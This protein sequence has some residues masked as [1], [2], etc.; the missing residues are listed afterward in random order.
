MSVLIQ[1]ARNAEAVV[2]P[3]GRSGLHIRTIQTWAGHVLA[4]DVGH[5]NRVRGR[6]DVIRSYFRDPFDSFDDR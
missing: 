4:E 2:F 3:R 1:N 5:G 6:G